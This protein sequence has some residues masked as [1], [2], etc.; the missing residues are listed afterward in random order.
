MNKDIICRSEGEETAIRE[1][2]L[3][4]VRRQGGRTGR[5]SDPYR[6]HLAVS[7]GSPVIIVESSVFNPLDLEQAKAMHAYLG[8]A[9]AAAETNAL[10]NAEIQDDGHDYFVT[11][12]NRRSE[13]VGCA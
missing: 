3:G 5:Q 4:V 9:I 13:E 7:R 2:L 10:A 12:F 8:E 6:Y 11:C 1:R